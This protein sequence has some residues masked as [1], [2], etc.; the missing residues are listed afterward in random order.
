MT[1]REAMLEVAY[2][3]VS[4]IHNSICREGSSSVTDLTIDILHKMCLLFET[5]E[6]RGK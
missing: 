1:K 4:D 3:L 6:V 5:K 2:D